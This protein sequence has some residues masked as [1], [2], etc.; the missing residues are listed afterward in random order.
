[1]SVTHPLN[2]GGDPIYPGMIGWILNGRRPEPVQVV[3]MYY[4]GEGVGG[5]PHRLSVRYTDGVN[6]GDER[7]LHP[8]ELYGSE[9]A[10]RDALD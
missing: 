3:A 6:T 4:L 10:A 2:A 9:G 7:G 5:G 8:A 1:M